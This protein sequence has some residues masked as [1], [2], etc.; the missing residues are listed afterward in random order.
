MMNIGLCLSAVILALYTVYRY[1][2]LKNELTK[3]LTYINF[4]TSCIYTAYC[5]SIMNIASTLMKEGK[6]ASRI[7]HKSMNQISNE[8]LKKRL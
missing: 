7:I 3:Q 2:T 5:I 6:E 1:I 4:L 8:A